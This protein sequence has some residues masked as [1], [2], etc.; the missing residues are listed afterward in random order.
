M[1]VDGF[2]SAICS[3]LRGLASLLPT[4]SLNLPS[5]TSVANALAG[6]DSLVPVLLPLQIGA[7]C[8]AGLAAFVAVRV[9]V[10]V[11]NVVV[12]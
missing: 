1:I 6:L 9:V 3:I 12:P 4:G 10:Y 8:L 7:T 11:V 2:V 5:A